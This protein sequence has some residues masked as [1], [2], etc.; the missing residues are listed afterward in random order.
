M[1][2]ASLGGLA[3]T[4]DPTSVNWD[5]QMK[6]AQQRTLG[7]SVIQV[8]GVT[9]GDMTVSGVFGAGNAAR[10]DTAGWQAQERFRKQVQTWTEQAIANSGATPLR[11]LFPAFKWDFRVFVKGFTSPDG[12]SVHHNNEIINPRWTLTL[13]VVADQTGVVTK[14]I[15]DAYLSRLMTGVG[16]KQTQFNGPGSGDVLK[17][18]GGQSVQSYVESQLTKAAG[19]S[20]ANAKAPTSSSSSSSKIVVSS[21]ASIKTD[22]QT[23]YTVQGKTASA[24]DIADWQTLI[25]YESTNNPKA[26]NPSGASGYCQV[27]PATFAENAL[28]PYDK[29]IFD[30]VS[31]IIAADRYATGRYGGVHN[32]PGLVSLRAG[33]PYKGY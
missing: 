28:A 22:I 23:A 16:W 17:L 15:K 21:N 2:L 10:G 31:N 26:E 33:G 11:F 30:P 13:F 14:G 7:G 20:D 12:D 32:T 4:I 5:Y 1:G 27:K 3:F 18:L 9:L 6:T 25:Q 29:D 8:Y 24:Q 19:G